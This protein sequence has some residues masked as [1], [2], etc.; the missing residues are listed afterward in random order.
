MKLVAVIIFTA[1]LVALILGLIGIIRP[2]TR[3]HMPTRKRAAVWAVGGLAAMIFSL[4]TSPDKPR[5]A[6]A[7]ETAP[8]LTQTDERPAA[9]RDAAQREAAASKA[10]WTEGRQLLIGCKA[11]MQADK[12]GFADCTK[13]VALFSSLPPQSSCRMQFDQ[14]ERYVSERDKGNAD[15]HLYQMASI[16]YDGC[17]AEID[18]FVVDADRELSVRQ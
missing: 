9:V 3:L 11:Q 14:V 5:D 4:V 18:S 12:G 16:H 10:N 6:A 7:S 13:G 2:A 8:E 17:L 15:P 1:G